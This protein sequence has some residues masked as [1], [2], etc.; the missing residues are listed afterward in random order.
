MMR[1]EQHHSDGNQTATYA[2]TNKTRRNYGIFQKA[3]DLGRIRIPDVERTDAVSENRRYN[4]GCGSKG[5]CARQGT[6]TRNQ[7]AWDQT[8]GTTVIETPTSRLKNEGSLALTV[9]S[10]WSASTTIR[11]GAASCDNDDAD[12]TADNDCS[13]ISIV[14]INRDSTNLGNPCINPA[15]ASTGITAGVAQATRSK[16]M[17]FDAAG[18]MEITLDQSTQALDPT[19]SET[20]TVCYA[21][22]GGATSDI[23]W[24][25]SYI[26][27]KVSEISSLITMGVTHTTTGQIPNVVPITTGIDGNAAAGVRYTY[28]GSLATGKHISFVDATLNNGLP[29][30]DASSSG[31]SASG[32]LSAWGSKETHSGSHTAVASTSYVQTLDTTYMD[33]SK[34]FAL[35]YAS[36]TGDTSD[37]SWKDSGIRVT[38]P[39]IYGMQ[40]MGNRNG[41]RG[42]DPSDTAGTE[43]GKCRP[44]V[45]CAEKVDTKS[46]TMTSDP[47]AQNRI[48]RG[49]T[50]IDYV[51]M[52]DLANDKYVS[53]APVNAAGRG[54][55]PCVSPF[56]AGGAANT[57][58]SG[59]VTATGKNFTIPQSTTFASDTVFAV[60]YSEARG[61]ATDHTWRDSYIR[62]VASDVEKL[63]VRLPTMTVG[64]ATGAVSTTDVFIANNGQIPNQAAN[65]QV[66]YYIDGTLTGTGG[67][68]AF[69]DSASTQLG[70]AAPP[71][72]ATH[73]SG[74]R[75]YN[76]CDSAAVN[77]AN[78]AYAVDT[79][80]LVSSTLDT[81]GLSTSAIYAVCYSLNHNS[82]AQSGTWVDSGLRITVPKL[83]S[84]D[85]KGLNADVLTG[86]GKPNG[87]VSGSRTRMMTS[88]F[89][90]TNQ[91]P[92][93]SASSTTHALH[94][95]GQLTYA[96]DIA[97]NERVALISA[98]INSGNPCVN[99]YET[100]A[101]ADSTHSGELSAVT[102]TATVTQNT[103]LDSTKIFALCYSDGAGGNSDI[104]WRDSY[105]RMAISQVALTS[106]HSVTHKTT[107]QIPSHPTLDLSLITSFSSTTQTGIFTLVDASLG[108]ASLGYKSFPFPCATVATAHT[109]GDS[110]VKSV[111]SSSSDAG[112]GVRTARLTTS[113]LVSRPIDDDSDAA[114]TGAG[115]PAAGDPRFYAV[116]YTAASNSG[117]P[118]ALFDSGIR[119]TVSEVVTIQAPSG[120]GTNRRSHLIDVGDL[121]G[122]TANAVSLVGSAAG[123][124]TPWRDMTSEPLATNRLPQ[125]NGQ[126]LYYIF[127]TTSN[128]CYK[129]DPGDVANEIADTDCAAGNGRFLSLVDASLNNNNPC[130]LTSLT[131]ASADSTHTGALTAATG[132]K[133]ISVDALALDATKTFAV[134]Y[135]KGD[136]LWNAA[137]GQWAT[138][139]STS[140]IGYWEDTYVRLQISEIESITTLG[141]T[142]R[143]YGQVPNTVAAEN[144]DFVIAGSLT[145]SAS[146]FISLVDAS[147]ASEQPCT[148]GSSTADAY[149]S[150]PVALGSFKCVVFDSTNAGSNCGVGGSAACALNSIC[151]PASSGCGD[152]GLCR[153]AASSFDTHPLTTT[154]GESVQY[155]GAASIVAH[156]ELKGRWFAVCY[157]FGSGYKD[158]GIR[159][160]VPRVYN[161]RLGS[162]YVGTPDRDHTSELKSTNRL[163]LFDG[164]KLTYYGDAA[165]Q[166]RFSLVKVEPDSAVVPYYQRAH[167]DLPGSPTVEDRMQLWTGNPCVKGNLAAAAAASTPLS[168][169]YSGVKQGGVE[170]TGATTGLISAQDGGYATP[171]RVLDFDPD[172]DNMMLDTDYALCYNEASSTTTD[173]R[174]KDTYIRFRLTAIEKFATKGVSHKTTGQLPHHPAGL[175]YHFFG[176]LDNSATQNPIALVDA[177]LNPTQV[178]GFSQTFAQPCMGTYASLTSG[179]GSWPGAS[180]HTG[181][182]IT[183]AGTSTVGGTV[184]GT[185]SA[186]LNTLDTTPLDTS[187]SYALCYSRMVSGSP[188]WEDTGIRLTVSKL[189]TIYFSGHNSKYASDYGKAD[190]G[191]TST[192]P[193]LQ[194]G[195]RCDH[196]RDGT[197]IDGV[198]DQDC[199]LTLAAN[200]LPEMLDMPLRYGGDLQHSRYISLVPVRS[201]YYGTGTTTSSSTYWTGT[202]KDTNSIDSN[203]GSAQYNP[204]VDPTI[205]ID[206][207]SRA[208]Y[209]LEGECESVSGLDG[210]DSSKNKEVHL[211]AA[212]DPDYVYTV[213][214]S[215]TPPLPFNNAAGLQSC[216]GTYCVP[217]WGDAATIA[218]QVTDPYDTTGRTITG[219]PTWVDSYIRVQ[220]S[221][222]SSVVA[223]G[224]THTDHGHLANHEYAEMLTLTLGGS[225]A[226][227][228]GWYSL[229]W[230]QRATAA[231][232]TTAGEAK[233]VS[234]VNEPCIS[235]QA[236][237]STAVNDW[238][239]QTAVYTGPYQAG[240]P[241]LHKLPADMNAC[242]F[243][244]SSNTLVTDAS[245]TGTA[246]NYLQ[247]DMGEP[248]NPWA[249]GMAS[250]TYAGMYIWKITDAK[251]EDQGYYLVEEAAASTVKIP[252]SGLDSSKVYA[253]CYSSGLDSASSAL[254]Y[255]SAQ[256]G[257]TG[258]NQVW[259]DTGMR[260]TLPEVHTF[261]DNRGQLPLL[262]QS[263]PYATGVFVS[264]FARDLTSSRAKVGRTV[265][266]S[267]FA[268][269]AQTT[270]DV[271]GDGVF[272]EQCAV[273]AFCDPDM[274]YNGGCGSINRNTASD[275]ASPLDATL[276]V[277]KVYQPGTAGPTLLDDNDVGGVCNS[278]VGVRQMGSTANKYALWSRTVYNK[279]AL[280]KIRVP[281]TANLVIE[282]LSPAAEGLSA[283]EGSFF[284]A[285]TDLNNGEPCAKPSWASGVTASSDNT[286]VVSAVALN[287]VDSTNSVA[288][289]LGFTL[290]NAELAAL[291]T[292]KTFTVCYACAKHAHPSVG[293]DEGGCAASGYRDSYVH[294]TV[295]EVSAISS[296]GISHQTQ[297]HIANGAAVG[298]T[299]EGALPNGGSLSLVEEGQNSFNP[300]NSAD[301][302]AS[303]D[304]LHSGPQ[305]AGSTSKTVQFDTSGLSTEYNFAVCYQRNTCDSSG[306][307][308]TDAT[309]MFACGWKDSGVRVSVSRVTKLTYNKQALSVGGVQP[310]APGA[311]DTTGCYIS[312]QTTVDYARD[313]TSINVAPASDSYPVA[314]NTFPSF[315]GEI[316]LEYNGGSAGTS[317]ADG[318]FFHLVKVSTNAD[319]NPCASQCDVNTAKCAEN[320]ADGVVKAQ[321]GADPPSVHQSG[322]IQ[323]G[324]G[325]TG[326]AGTSKVFRLNQAAQALDN[327]ATELFA[328]CYGQKERKN[329]C[330]QGSDCATA[331]NSAWRDSYIRL[332]PSKL[333][334]LRAYG[335]DHFTFGDIPSKAALTLEAS[336]L[337]AAGSI[338][339][340]DETENAQQPCM[341]TAGNSAGTALAAAKSSHVSKCA[342]DAN[343]VTPTGFGTTCDVNNDGVFAETCA[344]G[345]F[346]NAA[347]DGCG[348][349][350]TCTATAFDQTATSAL[351]SDKTYAVCFT[352]AAGDASDL[353]WAD[354]GI[355]VKTPQVQSITYSDPARVI[356]A[357]SCFSS[358]VLDTADAGGYAG[359]ADCHTRL[360]EAFGSPY[361]SDSAYQRYA[362]LPRAS[363]ISITYNGPLN[364]G[365]GIAT[366]KHISLVQMSVYNANAPA[367][368]QRHN[369]CRIA[370][371]A[372]GAATSTGTDGTTGTTTA[373]GL[374]GG[375]DTEGG[376]RYHTGA[377]TA[378]AG[379]STVTIQ[380]A[381]DRDAGTFNMLD[382]SE[383]F[384]VCYSDG[385][386]TTTDGGWR[387]SYIRVVLSKLQTLK[388]VHDDAN[389]VGYSAVQITT[390]GTFANVPSLHV[391]WD[392]SLLHD[393]W[394]RI[395]HESANN[396][397]P[398]HKSIAD[399]NTVG[400]ASTTAQL[401]S[402]APGS[403]PGDGSDESVTFNTDVLA[404][405]SQATGYYVVCY[406]TGDG[407][408]NDNTWRDSSLR[409]RFVR[410]SNS[411]KSRIVS[412]APARL[413]FSISTGQFDAER[414]KVVFLR[415]QPDCSTAP[416][417]LSTSD[418]TKVSRTMDY[419][420]TV[421]TTDAQD[422]CDS[423]FDGAYGETCHVGALCD[424]TSSS[425]NGG[426]GSGGTCAGTV[427][428]P[429]GASNA[430]P[431]DSA[432]LQ[433]VALT[434]G[435]YA[436]CLCLGGTKTGTAWDAT[437]TSYGPANG[438]GG[439]DAGSEY[440]LIGS[441]LKIV[442]KPN[443]GRVSTSGVT[444][445]PITA[446]HA[447]GVSQQYHVNIANS[448]SGFGIAAGDKL[449]FVPS[450]LGCGHRTQYS[451]DGLYAYHDGGSAN[452]TLGGN[453][454]GE[455]PTPYWSYQ[456]A[457]TVD[458]RWRAKVDTVCTAMGSSNVG[459]NCRTVRVAST[460]P[461]HTVAT[462]YGPAG[463]MDVGTA[464]DQTGLSSVTTGGYTTTQYEEWTETCALHTLCDITNPNNGGCGDGGGVCGSPVPG[465]NMADR[466]MPIALV[467]DIKRCTSYT[468]PG[469]G[470]FSSKCDLDGD[471]VFD[472]LC[473]DGAVCDSSDDGCGYSATA[474]ATSGYQCRASSASSYS[475]AVLL[476]TPSDTK[477]STAQSLSACFATQESLAGSPSDSTD[478][479]ELDFGLDVIANPSLGAS[480]VTNKIFAVEDSS[481]TFPVSD[482]TAQD[483]Y[484]FV[485]MLQ[486]TPFT[487][488]SADCTPFVCTA[489]GGS[490]IGTMQ[491]DAD[492]D[493]TK[494]DA[495]VLHARCDPNAQF[496]GY[497]GTQGT[498]A[499][500]V[501]TVNTLTHTG[502]IEGTGFTVDATTG[503]KTG[504]L[505]LPSDTT[506]KV[507]P[508]T[509][510]TVDSNIAYTS[511]ASAW[512]LAACLI[513]AGA[514][515]TD[516][517][518]VKQLDDILTVIK[519]PTEEITASMYSWFQGH[520]NELRFTQPQQGIDATLATGL[521]GD[522]VVLV[523]DTS[524]ATGTGENASSTPNCT[525]AHSAVFDSYWMSAPFTLAEAG[526]VTTG[527]ENGGTAKDTALAYGKVNELE[528]GIYT[529]CY[530]TA[531]SG[532]DSAGDFKPLA[533]KIEILAAPA[534]RPSL[535]APRSVILGQDI[536]VSWASNIGLQTVESVSNAWVGLYEKD[537][538]TDTNDCY[539]AY[540]F[541]T[542][543]ELTGTTIFS[544]S[545]YKASG[546]YEVRYFK[547][548]A[549][550]SPMQNTNLAPLT[551]S[552][553]RSWTYRDET[554]MDNGVDT[555]YAPHRYA[556]HTDGQ[557][558]VCKGLPGS[559]SET[560]VQC[561]LSAAAVSEAITVAGQDIDE[562]EDL[563]LT[564][565]LEAVFGNGNRG[566]YHRTAMRI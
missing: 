328:V 13:V 307:L 477:L 48:P 519:E 356:S 316:D 348:S 360:P 315:S 533:Q 255:D 464:A 76:P 471:G 119:L 34:T 389:G 137:P 99:P 425:A 503:A 564:T 493:G 264:K 460:I 189:D 445:T 442:N 243:D 83:I 514:I 418:G 169:E 261:R 175:V 241:T 273:G 372:A 528:T 479:T 214:Y 320:T 285:A 122:E 33:T 332:K 428:L 329:N 482:M 272:N 184:S 162:T 23:T 117:A 341:N 433:E 121:V 476:A 501:P 513:P 66:K 310:C 317:L 239:A 131:E 421:A 405:P 394:L 257:P 434:E 109:G 233:A 505:T 193:L 326:Q 258:S 352:E 232:P 538:C 537:A 556:Q 311:A 110:A 224:V 423:D 480:Q 496:N 256:M 207:M 139:A 249:C 300:C 145:S 108:A 230:Q 77:I 299:Y 231:A 43:D 468:T 204:C 263:S 97:A 180:L 495:C 470:T 27:F 128:G 21:K 26:R 74:V 130:V 399:I 400:S 132:E 440:T 324:N 46:R 449:F 489:V 527:D 548:D 407:T 485:P 447:S 39:K 344:V 432:A 30:S 284:V 562:T 15:T 338:A 276:Q 498:C 170:Y 72:A 390:I 302:E 79:A 459:T 148:E 312:Q 270:C 516:V 166:S 88:I 382:Y 172:T 323:A 235:T 345:A 268:A 292:A 91:L 209:S 446:R 64:T 229:V 297:G 510:Y 525:L 361:T 81:T 191:I 205:A 123:D 439:C 296:H 554:I 444:V 462:N 68:I 529:I 443:I 283:A 55:N 347:N 65:E 319:S 57:K 37:T 395:T 512:Y 409:L 325:V 494:D 246:D 211:A 288:Q 430:E 146:S 31:S 147:H 135:S 11:Q 22:G 212:L 59:S 185:K 506:L 378:P 396:G 293:A 552:Q 422:E 242:G 111:S 451:G 563:S 415:E 487:Q 355:R 18:N 335:I 36:G 375:D 25:D 286:N 475:N 452:P 467:G 368:S 98:D 542:P 165:D 532:G 424:I 343:G 52:G 417:A 524:S 472:E 245:Y 555:G 133:R 381:F 154:A 412:G 481:P 140:P 238:K 161:V 504:Q 262:M 157:N 51:Y 453:G 217:E 321:T 314:T 259:K 376:M 240:R 188:S 550:G 535:S 113:N 143:T 4:G 125:A 544:Q 450:S 177:S 61:T 213:C 546:Q 309:T 89:R 334:T 87:A 151:N 461:G 353:T 248:A 366:G 254:Q 515:T 202:P 75:N 220:V 469:S 339:L 287:S 458:R 116:C 294:F 103:L 219:S 2:T 158:S 322:S 19:E 47:V 164:Q 114:N 456:A 141:V 178:V 526:G 42:P 216:Y 473:A 362:T 126:N 304:T 45:P 551:S 10:H 536:V 385:T 474:S 127:S 547:G 370:L 236:G 153:T 1:A 413:T 465:S 401:Y 308:D 367:Y 120:Y 340:V 265:C 545:D 14:N 521:P 38:L 295:S 269:T 226:P 250:S 199:E 290:A 517:N 196:N 201:T 508:Y 92:A 118:S 124:G 197:T 350:G 530:A 566:R 247:Y 280:H 142:H 318:E 278:G 253:L 483:M 455:L 136:S 359:M 303:S 86:N 507:P 244:F 60:C 410:W 181:A 210:S 486:T 82:G 171:N 383:T 56:F 337:P 488:P 252:T 9:V 260:F 50:N 490:N 192:L 397:A 58:V 53:L 16:P 54:V 221:E 281:E 100:T 327:D 20:Y 331:D 565:G 522:I 190:R 173:F 70:D 17:S 543:E 28:D 234:S 435:H 534:T 179:D 112:S 523:R 429:S 492:H 163:P 198:Y 5:V 386:G 291:N 557:G 379:T 539:L 559:P 29:C 7:M 277:N 420:C 301:T 208:C 78:A 237:L 426:C 104:T 274:P 41:A 549:V 228:Q 408:L 387:D 374:A 95:L 223:T 85:Y 346:C 336:S 351:D 363:D 156:E 49:V 149:H 364:T 500:R 349:G 499:Q 168:S 518:N 271:N 67:H 427:Q 289:Q 62:I 134:C 40:Y 32:A 159:V 8:D 73:Y 144:L 393:Q 155:K 402:G 138:P 558:V 306:Q 392:G 342:E 129:E 520:I 502:L 160:T 63:R 187:K 182:L 373:G 553:T 195:N 540:Q 106:A 206:T 44:E 411:A 466:T 84:V 391:E 560:Y 371:E 35:C 227:T 107:G 354:S 478:Y 437:A 436:I 457:E 203:A 12:T 313:M 398:C 541:I 380:Q 454:A 531:A 388:A 96:G 102:K 222:V 6:P 251:L 414:D 176:T 275:G 305:T 218:T 438:N 183:D 298:I 333:S 101:A 561:T 3:V 384:A 93:Y 186:S 416:M 225:S 115:T 365:T 279:Q 282:Y 266:Q 200:I 194:T 419:V 431:Q 441:T 369:P 90:A 69:M 404:N 152:S 358:T 267:V 71:G 215:D 105:I 497:C 511:Y 150:G 24:R 484:Y 406:A 403:S 94:D 463:A 80:G 448:A 330:G 491:C 174:W 167:A 377:A 357:D 509:S